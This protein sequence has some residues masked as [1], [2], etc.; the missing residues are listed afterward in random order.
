[1]I[2]SIKR[3]F[4]LFPNI[5]GIVTTDNLTAITTAGYW[6]SQM[7]QVEAVNNGVFNWEIED[8]VLIYY[9]NGLIGFFT[10]DSESLA[11]VALS[12]SGGLSP[13]LSSGNIFVGNASRPALRCQAT[14]I[15]IIQALSPLLIT[16]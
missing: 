6:K 11:F 3:D 7:L 2:T 8:L 16:L 5:V 1:M 4:N 10:F 13:S 14:A 9:S 15:W 12:E